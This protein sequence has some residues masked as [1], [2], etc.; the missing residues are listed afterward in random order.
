MFTFTVTWTTCF[1][2]NRFLHYTTRLNIQSTRNYRSIFRAVLCR[3]EK[4]CYYFRVH[5]IFEVIKVGSKILRKL[6]FNATNQIATFKMIHYCSVVLL[7]GSLHSTANENHW[8]S[9]LCWLEVKK[10]LI[11]WKN[12][13]FFIS[14]MYCCSCF[15]CESKIVKVLLSFDVRRYI[16]KSHP[17]M[18]RIGLESYFWMERFAV[19]NNSNHYFRKN[20]TWISQVMT[21]RG[22]FFEFHFSFQNNVFEKH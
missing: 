7:C 12:N 8:R 13:T 20:S 11:M 21:W 1:C 16:F 3:S 19:W 15:F 5:K 10:I 2:S 14:V 9:A 17:E 22:P 6:S 4:V 18:W